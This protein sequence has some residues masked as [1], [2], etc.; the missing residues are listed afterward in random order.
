VLVLLALL[1]VVPGVFSLI[2]QPLFSIA[3]V[4][5]YGAVIDTTS[6]TGGCGTGATKGELL[7]VAALNDDLLRMPLVATAGRNLV[8]L[9][10]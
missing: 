9:V 1:I 7:T 6:K 4:V 2:R 10:V 5:D 8:D 3:D